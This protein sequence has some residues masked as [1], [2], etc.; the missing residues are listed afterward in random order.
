M[1]VLREVGASIIGQTRDAR[2]RG[3][4]ALRAARRDGDGREHA[5]DLRV[6]HEQEARRRQHRARAG[7]EVRRVA[8]S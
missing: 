2:A 1:R 3:Q 4:E 6:D 7:R 5:A 8:P